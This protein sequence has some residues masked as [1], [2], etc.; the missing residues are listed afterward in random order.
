MI[1]G[2]LSPKALLSTRFRISQLPGF[3]CSAPVNDRNFKAVVLSAAALIVIAESTETAMGCVDSEFRR[4]LTLPKPLRHG[5]LRLRLAH[6]MSR[7]DN[8][9]IAFP[10]RLHPVATPPG[11]LNQMR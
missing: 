2:R 9:A 4:K 10:I 5:D 8:F 11:F 6:R 7:H 3:L 1:V